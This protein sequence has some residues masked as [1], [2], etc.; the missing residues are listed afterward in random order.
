M[1]ILFKDLNWKFGVVISLII[2][3]VMLAEQGLLMNQTRVGMESRLA[4]KAAF[5]NTFYASLIGEALQRKD[6]VTLLQWISHLEEDPEVTSVVVVDNNGEVRY[7]ADAEK[8][9]T[10]WNDP[11]MQKAL[12][13]GDGVMNPFQ[14]TGG[15][16]LALVSPLKVQGLPHPIGVVR[17]EFTY[18]HVQD[19]LKKFDSSFHLAILGFISTAVGLI[20]V[21]VRLWVTL[22]LESAEKAVTGLHLATAEPDLPE[23]S[24]EFGRLNK[25]LNDMILRFRVELQEQLGTTGTA[26]PGETEKGLVDRLLASFLPQV[27]VIIAGKDNRII[28]LT[29]GLSPQ[30]NSAHLLDLITDRNFATLVGAAYQKEGEVVRGPVLFQDQPYEAGVLCIPDN[31]SKIVKAVITLQAQSQKGDS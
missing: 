10:Q 15:R 17:I 20:M 19:Q 28:S 7:H 29:G 2:M 3:A 5:I 14:N 12:E 25:A 11:L 13:S 6:D 16:A 4:E 8:L 23:R 1:K 30:G 9:G 31:E 18:R 22:P 24:D 21:F 26:S 27:R